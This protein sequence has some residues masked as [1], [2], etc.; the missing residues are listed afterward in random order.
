[1]LLSLILSLDVVKKVYSILRTHTLTIFFFK[2][3]NSSLIQQKGGITIVKYMYIMY[4]IYKLKMYF[5]NY[6]YQITCF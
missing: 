6:F 1:M 2:F 4:K 5:T 3:D